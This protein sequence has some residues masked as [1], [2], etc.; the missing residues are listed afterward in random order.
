M[1]DVPLLS[2]SY[3]PNFT[4][5]RRQECTAAKSSPRPRAS[6]FESFAPRK[7]GSTGRYILCLGMGKPRKQLIRSSPH[8]SRHTTLPHHFLTV[9]AGTRSALQCTLTRHPTIPQIVLCHRG[10]SNHGEHHPVLEQSSIPDQHPK[11]RRR[12]LSGTVHQRVVIPLPR[13]LY[14]HDKL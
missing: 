10:L 13:R 2:G 8:T 6:L 4:G 11:C 7:T 3:I 14:V 5:M 12:R 1:S 9:A